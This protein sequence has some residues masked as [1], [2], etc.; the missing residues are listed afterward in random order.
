[1]SVVHEH[2]GANRPVVLPTSGGRRLLV[3]IGRALRR[4][5]P[6]CGGGGVF[7]GWFTL[8]ERC[9][10]CN[11]LYEHEEGFFLGSY[12]VNIGFTELVTVL[13]VVWLIAATDLSVLQMQM[14]GVGLAVLMPVL[15]YPIALLLWV[16]L[17]NAIH[18]PGD[19]SH[20]IRK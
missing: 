13:I 14:Y 19:F 20:R 3:G 4:A 8:R 2:E 1:M 11:T 9:P 10:H 7:K 15:F 6:Y 16:A 5:C 12:V 18:A 17:D